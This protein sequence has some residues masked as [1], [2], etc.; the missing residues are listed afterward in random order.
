M[1]PTS[2]TSIQWSESG[3][4]V[5]SE[6]SLTSAETI[7]LNNNSADLQAG[8]TAGVKIATIDLSN[9]SGYPT[10]LSDAS[11]VMTWAFNMRQSKPN[12]GGF[13]DTGDGGVAFALAAAGSDLDDSNALAV[14]LG[15]D[16][17]TDAI[18]LVNYNGGYSSNG[19]FEVL[20]SGSSDLSNQYV[21]VKVTYDP[22]TSPSTWT[23][24]ASSDANSFPASNPRTLDGT[25]QV[26]Q[27]MSDVGTGNQRKYVGLLW[28]HGATDENAIFDDI[29]VTDPNGRLPVELASFDVVTNDR[30]AQLSWTTASETNNAGFAVQR[31][32]NGS[33]EKVGFVAGAGTVSQ[34]QDYGF[35]TSALSP[36]RHTFRLRQED[37]DGS[38][39]LGPTRTVVVEPTQSGLTNTGAN[40]VRGGT[41]ATFAV[42]TKDAQSV[43]VT[44]V[45]TLGQ[46]VRTVHEGRVP[47]SSNITIETTSLSSGTYF[48]R[49]KGQSFTSTQKFTVVQ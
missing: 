2:P 31:K 30:Q 38:S 12:P 5:G 10:T 4:V 11:G 7:R 41:P 25:D 8:Q 27:A 39:S 45:N 32:V 3:Q 29:Y 9:V 14:T 42:T 6:S 18:Q 13:G 1:T 22:S 49:A 33:F 19:D 43:T 35:T 40:P 24:H 47:S 28:D 15:E 16:G 48:L 17:S 20:A 36:G 44:L 34:P 37:V 26:D 46:T 21:S 23:L